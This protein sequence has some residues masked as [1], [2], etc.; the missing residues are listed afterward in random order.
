MSSQIEAQ[1]TYTQYSQ[2]Y[3]IAAQLN[4]QAQTDP[5]KA[6]EAQLASQQVSLKMGYGIYL[7][8]KAKFDWVE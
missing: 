5:S 6:A 4:T 3:Q 8:Q 7:C 1:N 2:L